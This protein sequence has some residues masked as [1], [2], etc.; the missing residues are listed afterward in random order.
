MLELHIATA[1]KDPCFRHVEFACQLERAVL[2][3]N[4]EEGLLSWLNT[5]DLAKRPFE[6]ALRGRWR[7]VHFEPINRPV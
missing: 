4:A 6:L 2:Q 3:R 5:P 1:D 7:C